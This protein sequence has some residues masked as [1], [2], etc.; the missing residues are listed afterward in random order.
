MSQKFQGKLPIEFGFFAFSS[1]ESSETFR[2]DKPH[3]LIKDHWQVIS[4]R[5]KF[6]SDA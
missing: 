2:Y 5:K 3:F 1:R 4:L 6:S